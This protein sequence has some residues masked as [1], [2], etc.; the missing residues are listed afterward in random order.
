MHSAT[1]AMTPGLEMFIQHWSG[2]VMAYPEMLDV[3]SK[4]EN[5]RYSMSPEAFAEQCR[6]WV[7]GGVQIIGG[8]CGS[9]VEHIR[10]MVEA[11]PDQVGA[12]P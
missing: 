11:L 6:Q 10:Q 4:D 5:A 12:R 7:E 2:P 3:N 9:T 8:C 1:A